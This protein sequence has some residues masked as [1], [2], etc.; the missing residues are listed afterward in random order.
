MKGARENRTGVVLRFKFANG[1]PLTFAPRYVSIFARRAYV[2]YEGGTLTFCSE[3]KVFRSDRWPTT[4]TYKRRS[5]NYGPRWA[6]QRSPPL[7]KRLRL[8]QKTTS[9]MNRPEQ[10][11]AL[12]SRLRLLALERRR[13]HT[14]PNWT[15]VSPLPASTLQSASVSLDS[16]SERQSY[17]SVTAPTVLTKVE[18]P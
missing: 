10:Y 4:K 5:P 9:Y 2:Q 11:L 7:R 17:I 8:L 6:E 16:L 1:P 3:K 12:L 15:S 14:P 18:R 13:L